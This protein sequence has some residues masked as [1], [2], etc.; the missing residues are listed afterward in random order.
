MAYTHIW[1]IFI[2]LV[3]L[4]DSAAVKATAL[5]RSEDTDILIQNAEGIAP[6]RSS[7]CEVLTWV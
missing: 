5:C 6:D 3:V 2:P 4:C 1:P 7:Q